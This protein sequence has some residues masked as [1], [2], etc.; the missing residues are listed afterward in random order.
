MLRFSQLRDA[1]ISR[2]RRWHSKSEEWTGADWGNAM[3][4]ECGEACNLVKKLRRHETGLGTSYNTAPRAELLLDLADE[5]ADLVTYADL[6]AAHYGIDLGRAVG[7]KFNRVSA[8]QDFPERL[9]YD[10]LTSGG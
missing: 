1:N 3:A 4:G 10:E 7:V 8:A 6:L 2:L 5:L 9:S